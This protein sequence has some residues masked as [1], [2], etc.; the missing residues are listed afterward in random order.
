MDF[1]DFM[2]QSNAEHAMN[3]LEIILYQS[4]PGRMP[5][6]LWDVMRRYI[7]QRDHYTCKNCQAT[8]TRLD[9]H[10]IVPIGVGGSNHQDN[11]ATLCFKCHSSIHP[12]MRSK[13]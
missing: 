9:V 1:S 10:H 7:L 4:W 11:L 12:H 6:D 2:N 13:S 3:S 8:D 5:D